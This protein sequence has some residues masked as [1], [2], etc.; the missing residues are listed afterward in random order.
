MS[1]RNIEIPLSRVTKNVC[2]NTIYYMQSPAHQ[3]I[4]SLIKINTAIKCLLVLPA[5]L[6][7]CIK[8]VFL[9]CRKIRLLI[10]GTAYQQNVK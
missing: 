1:I 8:F 2:A 9:V 5:S 3:I 6:L 4:P 10:T 7:K